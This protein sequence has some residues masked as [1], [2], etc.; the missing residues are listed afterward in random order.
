MGCC[1]QACAHPASVH[2]LLDMAR[3]GGA[4]AGGAGGA[5]L[6]LSFLCCPPAAL[7]AAKVRGAE[8]G[9]LLAGWLANWLF[10]LSH[11]CM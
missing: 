11:T 9:E 8:R 5:D 4:G 10:L 2:F 1:G 6:D 7:P 3:G